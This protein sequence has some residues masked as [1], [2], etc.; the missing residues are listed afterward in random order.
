MLPSTWR[1]T[2]KRCV[3]AMTGDIFDVFELWVCFKFGTSDFEFP[4]GYLGSGSAG[5][6]VGGSDFPFQRQ[7]LFGVAGR[8]LAVAL[9]SGRLGTTAGSLPPTSGFGRPNRFPRL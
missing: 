8:V 7:R 9:S 4:G 6:G 3:S 2:P 1:C 5:L